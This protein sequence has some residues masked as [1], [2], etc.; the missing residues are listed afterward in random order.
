MMPPL[1]KQRNADICRDLHWN[2]T[3]AKKRFDRDSSYSR[4]GG[5]DAEALCKLL[6]NWR[7][8]APMRACIE[9]AL[10]PSEA[11]AVIDGVCS[12]K[13]AESVYYPILADLQH[14][15]MEPVANGQPWKARWIRCR[16]YV[17]LARAAGFQQIVG[18]VKTVFRLWKVG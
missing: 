1:P 18:L 10:D 12:K 5:L 8:S 11:R 4:V 2:L 6:W 3:V 16:G 9:E 7:G 15:W 14:E 17:A 13:A